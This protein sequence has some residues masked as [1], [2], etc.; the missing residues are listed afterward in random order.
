MDAQA[1]DPEWRRMARLSLLAQLEADKR[2][3]GH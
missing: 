3:G 2:R 1:A